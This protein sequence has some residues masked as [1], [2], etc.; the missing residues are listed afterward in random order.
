MT[1][2]N[3]N[4]SPKTTDEKLPP[5]ATPPAKGRDSIELLQELLTTLSPEDRVK[6]Q[7]A[8]VSV[9]EGDLEAVFTG[10]HK[11]CLRCT[12]CGEVALF[13]VGTK[14]S[15][16]GIEY[17][18]PPPVDQRFVPWFQNLEPGD[19]DRHAPKCQNCAHPVPLQR[20]GA[21]DFGRQRLQKIADFQGTRDQRFN[22]RAAR[23][24]QDRITS[25][26]A[27]DGGGDAVSNSYSLPNAPVSQ[28]I[29]QQ[30]GQGILEQIEQTAEV[31]G[32]RQG[33][34]NGFR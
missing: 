21:F 34:A 8:G 18:Q 22:T 5:E 25:E 20:S 16:G 2:S 32:A 28:T 13:F 19:I 29:E 14:F 1:K 30:H 31:T 27:R 10:N 11:W 17:D 12:T 9:P 6:L 4:Q 15:H 24:L 33:L 3:S 23:A 26:I 7:R